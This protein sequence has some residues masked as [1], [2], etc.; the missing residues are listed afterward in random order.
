MVE[1]VDIA[2]A[3][4]QL[5][6]CF[7]DRRDTARGGVLRTRRTGFFRA[8]GRLTVVGDIR[9]VRLDVAGRAEPELMKTEKLPVLDRVPTAAALPGASDALQR[10]GIAIGADPQATAQHDEL[11]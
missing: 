11:P 3:R 10:V 7:E 2:G 6:G 5:T 1:T 4:A 9:A 8:D